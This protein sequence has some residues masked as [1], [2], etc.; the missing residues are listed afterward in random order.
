[1]SNFPFVLKQVV[2]SFFWWLIVSLPLTQLL[3]SQGSSVGAFSSL[4]IVLLPF[5]LWFPP[6]VFLS[7]ALPFGSFLCSLGRVDGKF[8]VV[9][10][11]S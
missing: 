7:L 11:C 2:R 10:H 5:K 4:L 1:M 6:R 9:C 3:V 8:E